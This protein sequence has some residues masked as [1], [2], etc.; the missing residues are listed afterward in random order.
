MNS[1]T[2]QF[3]K[4]LAEC[5][6]SIINTIIQ[7]GSSQLLH[8]FQRQHFVKQ[9]HSTF[10]AVKFVIF[11]SILIH[12]NKHGIRIPFPTATIGVHKSQLYGY[13]TTNYSCNFRLKCNF[14]HIQTFFC[15]QFKVHSFCVVLILIKLFHPF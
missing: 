6:S 4:G 13:S 9:T 3:R 10:S 5:S 11:I 7:R 14:Y 15:R 2:L 1:T 8:L 12:A